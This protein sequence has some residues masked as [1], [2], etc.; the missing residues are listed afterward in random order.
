[1]EHPSG[2]W[3]RGPALACLEK[4]IVPGNTVVDL[5]CGAGYP[6]LQMTYMVGPSG[7]VIGVECHD[8]M[9]AEAAKYDKVPNLKFRKGDVT[10]TV[11]VADQEAHVVA[12]FMVCHNL[13]LCGVETMLCE[14]HRILKPGGK[15]V[16]LTMHPSALDSDWDLDFMVYSPRALRA[17]RGA[18]DKEGV[19]VPGTVKN[20]GGGSKEVL[21]INHT[22]ENM[23]R[24][25]K[26]ACLVL[27]PETS[28]R[29]DGKTAKAKFGDKAVRRLPT[30]P[31]FWIIVLDKP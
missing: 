6:S 1:M 18:T 26:D 28:L 12:S 22:R 30:T 25:I 10:K 5:G 19:H 31:I 11:P 9:L 17:Y 21:M 7:Q 29:I 27:G 8:G 24:A 2:I 13:E 16:F 23:L 15:A 20:A 14:T 4:L 3:G